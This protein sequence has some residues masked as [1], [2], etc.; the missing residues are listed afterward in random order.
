MGTKMWMAEI[1]FTPALTESVGVN[2]LH[3]GHNLLITYLHFYR[4]YFQSFLCH[5]PWIG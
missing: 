2:L 3:L 4:S 5:D 1:E